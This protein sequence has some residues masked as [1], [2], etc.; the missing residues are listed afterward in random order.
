MQNKLEYFYNTNIAN[1]NKKGMIKY[2]NKNNIN[3]ILSL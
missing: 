3:G 1:I 2:V